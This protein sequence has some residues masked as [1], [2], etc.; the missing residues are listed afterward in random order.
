MYMELRSGR[1]MYKLY[2]HYTVLQ[3]VIT[4][5]GVLCMHQWES[6]VLHTQTPMVLLKNQFPLLSHCGR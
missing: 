2:I 3:S 6:D 1:F 5:E 4:V